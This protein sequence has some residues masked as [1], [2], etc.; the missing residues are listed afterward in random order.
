M[1][2]ISNKSIILAV[3]AFSLL[4]MSGVATEQAQPPQ[5][6][7]QAQ[8]Q[9]KNPYADSRIFVEAFV[10]EV[11]LDALYKSG[12]SPI[13]QKPNAVSMKNILEC[14]KDRDKA[15]I[16]SGAKVAVR[17]GEKGEMNI[18]EQKYSERKNE[19]ISSTGAS[20]TKGWAPYQ[21]QTRF[22]ALA[23]LKSDTAIYVELDFSQEMPQQATDEGAPQNRVSRMWRSVVVASPGKPVIV[24][25]IQNDQTAAFLIL[26]ADIENKEK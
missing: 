2:S 22:Q 17:N 7:P 12:V 4:P 10:V 13:G 3:I 5:P 24:G 6:A 1:K 8:Q 14:L 21:I 15:A 18:T 25:A 9:E 11:K 26:S 16:V 19:V 23:Y 20:A